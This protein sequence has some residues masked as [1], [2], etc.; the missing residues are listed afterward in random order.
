MKEERILTVLGQIDESYIQETDPGRPW[1]HPRLRTRAILLAACLTAL[2]ALTAAAY[3]ANWFGLRDLLLP[4]G[5]QPPAGGSS[6]MTISLAGYR[7]SPEWQALAEWQAFLASRGPED[8]P[9]PETGDQLDT[10]FSRYNCYQVYSRDRAEAM[11]AIAARYDLK[12]H[13]TLFDLTAN[14]ELLEPLDAAFGEITGLYSTMYEDGTFQAEGTADLPE[15]GAWDFLLLR[16]VRGTFHDALLDLTDSQFREQ[17]YESTC[18][19]PVTLV[20]GESSGLILADL[21]DSFVTVLLPG[22]TDS[23]LG[24]PQLA[25]LADCIDFSALTPVHS[26][27][28]A[29]TT[30]SPAGDPETRSVYAAALRNLLHSGLF[31]DGT[32]APWPASACSRF[33][34]ADV[35]RD[36]MEELILLYEDG[37]TADEVGYILGYDCETQ[38][39]FSQLEEF[40][41]F[42]FLDTGDLKAL[43]S[44]NQTDGALWPY[45]LY[46]YY[47]EEDSYRLAGHVHAADKD[48]LRAN[49]REEDYPAQAD[50]SG[51]GTVYYIGESGWGTQPVDASAYHT[52]LTGQV[53]KA[54]EVVLDYLPLTEEAILTLEP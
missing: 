3:T 24:F 10:A 49:S 1:R 36:G 16:A 53:G 32:Q 9:V 18:G 48:L 40:P 46:R 47:P 11:E 14:P 37:A 34:V 20:L 29:G 31:P 44:H 21:T 12:L 39:L 38:S 35:D 23:G 43:S 22:G 45:S 42:C 6:S 8:S 2:L 52:W 26:P 4:R 50:A 51:T 7:D 30:P 27:Q 5:E 13:T 15:V 19:L 17:G 25:A 33:A 41:A 54:A 28:V